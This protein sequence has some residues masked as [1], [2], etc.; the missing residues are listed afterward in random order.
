MNKPI[1]R[2]LVANRGEIALR[3]IRACRELGIE[4]VQVYSEADANSL[5]VKLADRSVC[6]GRAHSGDTYLNA[7]FLVN[8]ALMHQADAVHPGYGFLSENGAFAEMCE[9]HG[10]IFIGPSAQVIRAMGDKAM[11]RKLAKEAGIRG[12]SAGGTAKH[13]RVD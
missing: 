3:V 1:R 4:T 9:Q 12:D 6:I 11:A 5:A 8:A 7:P 10:L 13:L 2:L